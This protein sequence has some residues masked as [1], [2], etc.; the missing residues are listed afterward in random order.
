MSIVLQNVSKIAGTETHIADVSL[1]FERGTL[2][3]LLGP[4]LSGKTSLMRLLA[5]LDRPTSGRVFADGCDVTDVHVRKRSVSIVYQQFINYPAL[6]VYE[7]IASPLRVKRVARKEIDRRVRAVAE[8]L[9][10]ENFLGRTPL[11]L[12]GGQQQRCA[13][14]RAVVKEAAL[15]LLDEPLANLDYKLREEIR[16]EL[17]RIFAETNSIF[18]Y[19]TTEPSEALLLG[20]NTAALSQGRLVQFG[21]TIDVYRYPIN[22]KAAETFSDPPL[23]IAEMVK[24]GGAITLQGGQT[25]PAA[26]LLAGL[27]DGCYDIGVRAHEVRLNPPEGGSLSIAG[28]VDVT[29]ITGSESFIHIRAGPLRWVALTHGVHRIEPGTPA[30]VWVD[31]SRMF[32]FAKDGRTIAVPAARRDPDPIP[33][34]SNSCEAGPIT[35]RQHRSK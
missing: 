24:D 32:V 33:A 18:V 34:N 12:S 31:L 22:L 21:C 17:P 11:Q 13:I 23:N 28:A 8:M 26:G 4:T 30:T 2:N 25:S 1:C 5:G 16:E 7:N 29:E 15:V 10:L 20:G 6:T 35:G 19:A 9:R 3:V 27:P 14:A